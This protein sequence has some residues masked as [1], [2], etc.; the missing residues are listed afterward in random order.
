MTEDGLG[1]EVLTSQPKGQSLEKPALLFVHGS[2]HAAWC[3]AEKFM[4]WFEA[5]GYACHA[6]S[7]RAQGNSDRPSTG[8][9]AGPLTTHTSDLAHYIQTEFID[10]GLPAPVIVAHSFGGIVLQKY[11]HGIAKPGTQT[12]R[13]KAT[14]FGH[15]P[16]L[17]GVAYLAS[18]PPSNKEMGMRFVKKN[19]MLALKFMW[20]SMTRSVVTHPDTVAP[21]YFS[22]DIPRA[23]LVKYQQQMAVSSPMRL[24]DMADV[25]KSMPIPPP[26]SHAPPAFI[27]GGQDDKVV[28]TE[29]IH[30]LAAFYKVD[31]VIL[32][33]LAH[34]V[35]LDTRWEHAA[36]SLESWLSSLKLSGAEAKGHRSCDLNG[37]CTASW[38]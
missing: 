33:G 5:R 38:D 37:S 25:S 18:L 3:W 7:M 28:D 1:L 26:P 34:D 32:P 19:P 31:P 10:H 6:V 24:V 14:Q 13:S 2:Y 16:Q 29:A 8:K 11:V 22:H 17:S 23:E 35:A 9:A 21:F 36:Q 12:D 20:H 30:E 15:Y 27:L 4:P